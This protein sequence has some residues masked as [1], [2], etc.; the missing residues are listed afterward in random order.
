MKFKAI[1]LLL[2][3]LIAWAISGATAQ[4]SALFTLESE[5]PI[6]RHSDQTGDWDDRFTDPGAVLFHDGKFHMFRNGFQ[7]W[8][9]SVQIG[10]LTSDDGITWQ[11]ATPDPV[12]TTAEV[13]Y[14]GLA[15]LA[16]SALVMDDGTWVLYFY[17][18]DGQGR[19]ARNFIGRATAASPLGPWT[20][21]AEPLLSPG[22]E[23]SWDDVGVLGSRVVQDGTG[24]VMYYSAANR[25]DR[26]YAGIGMARS[27]DGITW[28]KY[29]DP[30]TTETAFAESDPVLRPPDRKTFVHQ[31][32][33]HLTGSGWVMWYRTA[34]IG[35][36]DSRMSIRY[37]T[38][39][40][41]IMWT[42][43]ETAAWL[44]DTISQASG[45]WW[46]ASAYHDGTFYLYVE[47]G[48]MAGTNIYVGTFSGELAP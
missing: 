46:T 47:A 7:N 20:V 24:Y 33:V 3:L 12:L 30:A 34:P 37:A 35:Q 36:G 38:S 23:G 14:A 44:P 4:D 26:G 8:P 40:D 2:F 13:P 29:D 48:S 10:Y 25:R 18:W 15:A 43:A 45:F 17:T 22:V 11:E 21:A 42:P 5:D 27:D 28:N 19:S 32:S 9:G 41:G 31:P 6:I 1:H 16:S 39:A